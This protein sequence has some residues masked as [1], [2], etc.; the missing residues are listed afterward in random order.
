M[1]ACMGTSVEP[2]SAS[3]P[4]G[5]DSRRRGE[6]TGAK[7]EARRWHDLRTRPLTRVHA[8]LLTCDYCMPDA[9]MLSP[10]LCPSPSVNDSYG[11]YRYGPYSYVLYIVMVYTVMAFIVTAYTSSHISQA[12]SSEMHTAVLS[13]HTSPHRSRRGAS[14]FICAH[15]YTQVLNTCLC[16][17]QH[18]TRI[19]PIIFIKVHS[20]RYP[21]QSVLTHTHDV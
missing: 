13:R 7:L 11:P 15:A 21:S 14:T 19:F 3:I 12:M 18:Y 2:C 20:C 16:Y 4:C 5:S 1:R 9:R 10:L 17:T 6:A 8:H